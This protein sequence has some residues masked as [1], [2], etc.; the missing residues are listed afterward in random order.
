MDLR[1]WN[2]IGRMP[3]TLAAKGFLILTADNEAALAAAHV[4]QQPADNTATAPS[5]DLC[6]S[7]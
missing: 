7:Q 4:D 6:P 2:Q 5:E 3:T 1:D